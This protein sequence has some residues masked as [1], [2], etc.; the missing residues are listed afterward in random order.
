MLIAIAGLASSHPFTDARI[1]AE[2]ADLVVCDDDPARL[3]R[4]RDEHP[5]ARVAGDLGELLA[6]DPDGVVLTVPT[7]QVAPALATVLGRDLPCFVNKPAAASAAQLAALDK[8]VASAPHRVLTSSVL[9]FAPGFTAFATDPAQEVLAAQVTV[10]HDVARWADGHN[11]WQD[12]PQ[13]GGGMLVTMGVH[14]VELLVALFGPDVRLVGAA[15]ATRSYRTLASEDTAVLALRWSSGIAASVTFLGVTE[16]ESYE[17]VVHTPAGQR[18]VVLS[19]GAD[20]EV[21]L[22]YRATLAAFWSMVEGA[23]SPVPWEQTRAVLSAL[24]EARSLTA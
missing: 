14:G 19:G 22:G 7:P 24:A 16:T 8:A 11:P 12:D 2:R 9:R 17:V 10:R 6:A 15:A 1:L 20:A 23:P 3:A 13:V 4:F 5:A 18:R 21:T